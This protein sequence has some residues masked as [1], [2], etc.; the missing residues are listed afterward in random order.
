MQPFFQVCFNQNLQFFLWHT[1]HT[2]QHVCQKQVFFLIYS[3]IELYIQFCDAN[4][5]IF[6][7]FCRCRTFMLVKILPCK[8]IFLNAYLL[9]RIRFALHFSTKLQSFKFPIGISLLTKFYTVNNTLPE[10]CG[11]FYIFFFKNSHT[12][13]NSQQRP[14][15]IGTMYVTL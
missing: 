11:L 2:R 3:S 4:I 1:L 10:K 5:K 9:F 15:K 14:P 8:N 13:I 6:A 7:I 12:N